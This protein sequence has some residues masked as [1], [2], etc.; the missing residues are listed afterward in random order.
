M[1]VNWKVVAVFVPL[2]LS[3]CADFKGMPSLEMALPETF[4]QKPVGE[5]PAKLQKDWWKS[6][7]DETL[8]HI[9]AQLETQNLSLEQAR[10]RLNAA[11][12]DA[13]A[14]DYLPSLTTTTDAQYNRR[15]KGQSATQNLGVPQE[16]GKKITG[17]Y[18]AKI[19]ASWEVPIYGQYRDAGDIKNANIAFA[20]ADIEALRASVISEAVRLYTEMRAKQQEIIKREAIRASATQI[21]NYQSIKHAAGLIADT[22]LGSSKQSQ[23]SA[24]ND[25]RVAQSELVAREQQLAKL[26]GRVTPDELWRK[27]ADVPV[28]VLPAFDNAP[29][30][31]LRNRPDIRKAEA[32]VLAAAGDLELAKSEMYP[33]LTLSGNLLQSDNLTA[34]PLMGR[35][36][37]LGGVPLLSLPL[38]D[39]GKRLANAKIKDE[40]LSERASAY[41][42]TVIGAMNE[43]EEFWAAYRAAQGSEVSSQKN[44]DISM[45][46]SDHAALLFKQGITDGIETENAAIEAARS[47]ITH[48][49]SRADTI[50]KLTVLTKA[51]G[52]TSTSAIANENRHD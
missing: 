30:D 41:R 52:G 39:W 9:I 18:N 35:T 34:K 33:K 17:Y 43:V 37:Q 23:L 14:S 13:R 25:L 45:K 49:Q 40:N 10:F 29:L 48:L 22:E 28:F 26:L 42:E 36:V 24:Q 38:F 11:R 27:V 1:A 3:G 15:I 47:A 51:L 5:S 19:D 21:V 31:V 16:G 7:E 8:K 6:T 4:Q 46:A 50:T 44:T 20:Q 32:S 12:E 2:W